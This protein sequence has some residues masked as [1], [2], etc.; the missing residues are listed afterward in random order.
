MKKMKVELTFME[1]VLGSS[2]S[3]KDALLKFVA[4][5]IDASKAA[6]EAAALP[7]QEDEEEKTPMT[8]F[9]RLED[10][11]PFLWDYQVKGFFKSAAQAL[12]YANPGNKF[13]A[14]KKK[15]DLLVFVDERKIPYQMPEGSVIGEMVR[16]LRAQTAKG[17]RIALANSEMIPAGTKVTFTITVLDDSLYKY[18]SDWLN[19]GQYNGISQWRNARYGSFTWKEVA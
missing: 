17:E 14:Y 10:G 18:L 19:Y 16:P 3:N 4:S 15:I 9:P 8:V 6:E 7:E 12:N 5:D 1:P 13:T 2:P 11:T